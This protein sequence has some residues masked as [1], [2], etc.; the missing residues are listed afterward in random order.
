MLEAHD[1]A[2]RLRAHVRVRD[3]RFCAQVH[4][5]FNCGEGESIHDL[6]DKL[7]VAGRGAVPAARSRGL[8]S[9]RRRAASASASRTG[10]P[11]FR[12]R[13]VRRFPEASEPLRALLSRSSPSLG[14]ELDARHCRT[15]P[16]AVGRCSRRSAHRHVLRYLRWTLEDLYDHVG[17]PPQPPRRSSPVSAATT[18]FRRATSRSSCTSRSSALRPRRVLPE[19]PLLPFRRHARRRRSRSQP[20]LRGPARARGRPHRRRAA[21]ASPASPRRTASAS[22]RGATSRTSTRGSP[23]SSPATS[24]SRRRRRRLD[25]DYSCGTFTMYLGVRGLDLREHGFGSF[26][27]WHY[28]HDDINRHLRRPARPPRSVEPVALPLDAHAALRRAGPLP[29]GR[30]DPRGRDRLRPRPLRAPAPRRSPRLQPREEED[31]RDASST[32]SRPATSRG[33]ASTSSLRVAGTPATNARFCCARPRAT[34]TAR[35]SRPRTWARTGSRSARRSTTS[36]SSTRPR[37]SRASP[38]PSAPGCGSIEELTG[39]TV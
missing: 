14:D 36:G 24:T 20:R 31:P 26:N 6:L 12:D 13:L 38:A 4:Y 11:K 39:D 1:V 35:R 34:P 27:V 29:A 37:A 22:P 21:A 3:Y 5:V 7:G 23:R 2:R 28:P 17:M 33:C 9:R 16:H 25:Y 30:P 18:S 15:R 32:S 10:S 8:R 19:E